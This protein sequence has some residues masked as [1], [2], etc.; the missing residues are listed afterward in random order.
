MLLKEITLVDFRQFKGCQTISFAADSQKNVTVII[1]ENGSGKTTFAQAFTW[2]LYGHTDFTDKY[3]LCKSTLQD[4]KPNDTK[5]VKVEIKLVHK[6]IEYSII[7]EQNYIIDGNGRLREPNTSR[8]TIAYKGKDGQQEFV[9]EN[10]K[11]F[12]I[13]EILPEEL[14]RYFFFNGER[15]DNMSKEIQSGK[16]AEFAEAVKRLLGLDSYVAALAHIKGARAARNTVI[17]SYNEQYDANSDSRISSKIADMERCDKQIEEKSERRVEL[18]GRINTIEE[19]CTELN[20]LIER[21][22]DSEKLAK[23][24]NELEN[25]R[26]RDEKLIANSTG[27]VLNAFH[28]CYHTYF[29]QKLIAEAIE[30]LSSADKLDKGIPNIHKRTIEYLINQK[31]CICGAPIE[32]DNEAYRQLIDLLK[33]I[34]PKSLGTLI[35][36]F[37]E[38]CR[39]KAN[40]VVD[41]FQD[42]TQ[43]LSMVREKEDELDE[44]NTDISAIEEKLKAMQSVGHLQSKLMT[45]RGE[46]NKAKSEISSIDMT[47]GGLKKERDRAE[48]ELR[49]LSLQS[50]HNKKI[51]IYKTYA[52]YIYDVLKNDYDK[53]EAEVRSQLEKCI[54]EIFQN[55]YAGGMSLSIDEKYNIQTIVND[56]NDYNIGV[57]TSTAQSISIIFAFIAGVIKMARQNENNEMLSTEAYPLVMDAP[58]SAFDKTRIQ[59]VCDTLPKIAEQVIIFIKDTD[60][61]IAEQYL[62]DRI[63][64]NYQFDKKNSF[65]TYLIER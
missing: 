19:E 44:I 10:Q 48:T 12:R 23:Q 62:S 53:Q 52:E 65:E 59:T 8:L 42:I 18:E 56:F 54:N 4:M 51:E 11:D 47:I 38:E 6:N 61:E 60:G 2:C 49:E 64:E 43:R 36:S 5:T 45:Y 37:V 1:G 9:A 41:L 29:A 34:P 15:I 33:Y 55:I 39:L 27:D 35:N 32:L 14:S 24:K 30:V 46:A 16:S 28:K 50:G 25:K 26:E 63:G 22:K 13:K 17:G 3:V 20:V 31:R 21:N 57:E 7:R 58:L 40:N